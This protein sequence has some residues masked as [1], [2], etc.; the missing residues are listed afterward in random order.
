MLPSATGGVFA[1]SLLGVAEGEVCGCT[2]VHTIF[3]DATIYIEM[4]CPFGTELSNILAYV[5]MKE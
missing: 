4:S 1:L 2:K 3:I 5:H